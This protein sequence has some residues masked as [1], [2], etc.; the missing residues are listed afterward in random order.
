MARD[1][2]GEYGPESRRHDKPSAGSGGVTQ[3]RDVHNYSP[4]LGPTLHGYNCGNAGT[5]GTYTT[6]R[7]TS[8]SPGLHGSNKGM[9][10]NWGG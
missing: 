9:G 4:P 2:L 3:A 7:E 8:G 10:T 1:I 6:D 5:Q